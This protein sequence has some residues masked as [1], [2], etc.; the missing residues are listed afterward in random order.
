MIRSVKQAIVTHPHMTVQSWTLVRTITKTV[1]QNLVSL[2][3]YGFGDRGGI[4]FTVEAGDVL[5]WVHAFKDSQTAMT[6]GA[7]FIMAPA[8]VEVPFRSS[9]YR[10]SGGGGNEVQTIQFQESGR[11]CY[12]GLGHYGDDWSWGYLLRPTSTGGMVVD[13]DTKEIQVGGNVVRFTDVGALRWLAGS[14]DWSDAPTI[15]P[16]NVQQGDLIYLVQ[17]GVDPSGPWEESSFTGTAQFS[18]LGMGV[19]GPGHY[20][21]TVLRIESDGELHSDAFKVNSIGST[22]ST[23]WGHYRVIPLLEGATL[24]YGSIGSV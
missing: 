24:S 23:I 6:G 5:M 4:T 18:W 11:V 15:D 22:P 21:L 20:G 10:A 13:Q 14:Q 12:L 7:R 3:P 8:Y 2:A 1:Q 19:E 17:R 9:F 16:L